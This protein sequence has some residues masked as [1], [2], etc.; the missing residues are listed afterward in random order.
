MAQPGRSQ[1]GSPALL[2]AFAMLLALVPGAVAYVKQVTIGTDHQC[3]LL[4]SGCVKCWGRNDRY[5]LGYPLVPPEGLGA[6]GAALAAAPCVDVG[7]NVTVTQVEAGH[8]FTCVL[9]SIGEVRCWGW[10]GLGQLGR[11]YTNGALEPL[12]TNS[13]TA[14]GDALPF[15]ALGVGKLAK[16]ISAGYCHVAAL[17][18]DGLVKTWGCNHAGQLGYE[19]CYPLSITGTT[20]YCVNYNGSSSVT[21]SSIARHFLQY[22]SRGTLIGV[23]SRR[24]LFLEDSRPEVQLGL[25]AGVAVTQVAAGDSHTCALASDGSV[26]CWGGGCDLG[27]ALGRLFDADP[28]AAAVPAQ[29]NGSLWASSTTPVLSQPYLQPMCTTLG[30]T[31]RVT[32]FGAGSS[33]DGLN[34]QMGAN[35]PRVDLGVFGGARKLVSAGTHTCALLDTGAVKCW[36]RVESGTLLGNGLAPT[37]AVSLSAAESSAARLGTGVTVTDIAAGGARTCAILSNGRAKCWGPG[38][39]LGYE[40][41]LPAGAAGWGSGDSSLDGGLPYLELW[42]AGSFAGPV[43]VVQMALS[44]RTHNASNAGTICA[45]LSTGRLRCWGADGGHGDTLPRGSPAA[46]GRMGAALPDVPLLPDILQPPLPPFPPNPPPPAGLLASPPPPAPLPPL[47]R[48]A[49]GAMKPPAPAPPPP[50]AGSDAVLSQAEAARVLGGPGE[51]VRRYITPTAQYLLT[52]LGALLIFIAVGGLVLGWLDRR[53]AKQQAKAQGLAKPKFDKAAFARAIEGGV[54]AAIN[55]RLQV[56]RWALPMA[57]LLALLTVLT[58][59][60]VTSILQEQCVTTCSTV[61]LQLIRLTDPRRCT[62]LDVR[63]TLPGYGDT[64][65]DSGAAAAALAAAA[66]AADPAAAA[67]ATLAGAGAAFAGGSL[68]SYARVG[69]CSILHSQDCAVAQWSLLARC[70]AAA[71]AW[72]GNVTTAGGNGSSTLQS[73][74]RLLRDGRGMPD[75][76]LRFSPADRVASP[77]PPS[78]APSPP[79]APNFPPPTASA[80]SSSNSSSGSNGSSSNSSSGLPPGAAPSPP[81]PPLPPPPPPGMQWPDQPCQLH[82]SIRY[83]AACGRPGD[84][85]EG[86]PGDVCWVLSVET[87]GYEPDTR[88]AE[89]TGCRNTDTSSAECAKTS[90]EVVVWEKMGSPQMHGPPACPDVSYVSP[91]DDPPGLRSPSSGAYLPPPDLSAGLNVSDP[92]LCGGDSYTTDHGYRC[93]YQRSRMCQLVDGGS[94]TCAEV[95]S[96]DESELPALWLGA[97]GLGFAGLARDPAAHTC[98]PWPLQPLDESRLLIKGLLVRMAETATTQVAA[99]LK[100]F[101]DAT[102]RVTFDGDFAQVTVGKSRLAAYWSTTQLYCCQPVCP[103]V[104]ASLGNALG[105][106]VYIEMVFSLALIVAYM[107]VFRK[108]A[109]TLGLRWSHLASIVTEQD[110]AYD[111]DTAL[112]LHRAEMRI[113]AEVAVAASGMRPGAVGAAPVPRA[114]GAAV[115]VGAA[116]AGGGGVF[117]RFKGRAKALLQRP[118]A[119]VAAT[120]T[121]AGAA[122]AAAGAVGAGAKSGKGKGAAAAVAVAAA[123]AGKVAAEASDGAAGDGGGSGSGRGGVGGFFRR[124]MPS[125]LNPRVASDSRPAAA[126]A[127]ATAAA[128]AAAA[129]AASPPASASAAAVAAA[130][131]PPSGNKSMGSKSTK[132]TK[133][134]AAAATAAAAGDAGHASTRAPA[135]LMGAGGKSKVGFAAGTGGGGGSGSGGG[136]GEVEL[137]GG[138]KEWAVLAGQQSKPAGTKSLPAA[139]SKSTSGV[140]ALKEAQSAKSIAIPGGR[141]MSVEGAYATPLT[142]G[143]GG[144]GRWVAPPPPPA[145]AQPVATAAAVITPISTMDGTGTGG[146]GGGKGAAA[147]AAPPPPPRDRSAASTAGAAAQAPGQGGGGQHAGAAAAATATVAAGA[148]SRHASRASIGGATA[149]A[150]AGSRGSTSGASQGTSAGGAGAGAAAATAATAATAAGG[151]GGAASRTNAALSRLGGQQLKLG[152]PAVPPPVAVPSASP[153][154]AVLGSPAAAGAPGG[155]GAAAAGQ[156]STKYAAGNKSTKYGEKSQR[157]PPAAAA[158]AVA[159]AAAA[160]AR[161]AADSAKSRRSSVDQLLADLDEV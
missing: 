51:G 146:G 25:A 15:A 5:Q 147:A 70:A 155:S 41:P 156:K 109:N 126:T 111:R 35:L 149:A 48:L 50:P 3:A 110:I 28:E 161:G 151:G 114:G 37:G 121:A 54:V 43:R 36:G 100:Y 140:A 159:A 96:T 72:A 2:V 106:A 127:A 1:R 39:Y 117:Q 66:A 141:R 62:P 79:L 88:G 144:G 34:F 75:T 138:G 87:A 128:A 92:S 30:H 102:I 11:P 6:D 112:S 31:A 97:A 73:W 83:G 124:M 4:A 101:S 8:K 22:N 67:A 103:S 148:M 27:T 153:A 69:K 64:G 122:A 42:G 105:Y 82:T 132:A 47:P 143:T 157:A 104:L 13:S 89:G 130:A 26:R 10:N 93:L 20:N 59:A 23:Q 160:P 119:R 158:A 99:R 32:S 115:A 49:P 95:S 145:A 86:H 60:L 129:P 76:P 52:T 154:P 139:R 135:T 120:G 94:R 107:L 108:E 53:H 113:E 84:P 12:P 91:S 65:G 9:L 55:P 21:A 80:S 142:I 133:A 136:G 17:T 98:S 33:R 85:E 45:L 90:V 152:S 125:R 14:M 150:V 56:F 123:P 77:P 68:H 58:V 19:Y 29:H 44:K 46:A 131:Q 7:A 74:G 81:P 116:A 18:A 24:Q 71:A 134:A 63:D 137:A 40:Q 61:P 118:R 38:S 57:V 78:P 16:Q